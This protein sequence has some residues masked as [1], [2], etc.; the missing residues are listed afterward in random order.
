MHLGSN[1]AAQMS[2]HS[3]N[4]V[5][6]TRP[7][8]QFCRSGNPGLKFIVHRWN[9]GV[10]WNP[11]RLFVV[12]RWKYGTCSSILVIL[13]SYLNLAAIRPASVLMGGLLAVQTSLSLTGRCPVCPTFTG[14]QSM[15]ISVEDVAHECRELVNASNKITYI[16]ANLGKIDSWAR[17]TNAARW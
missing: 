15:R 6:Y 9:A 17:E 1:H 10:P 13:P 7:R 2:R 3:I 4:F 5:K 11:L 14:A 12:F 8:V 16:E